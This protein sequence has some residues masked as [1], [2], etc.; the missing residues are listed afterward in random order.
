MSWFFVLRGLT[1]EGLLICG[2][3]LVQKLSPAL[4]EIFQ[5]Y[6][7]GFLGMV[8]TISAKILF[9]YNLSFRLLDHEA[10]EHSTKMTIMKFLVA[11]A[12]RVGDKT[13]V[14]TRS[15]PCLR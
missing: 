14:F 4:E 1:L 9:S 8:H 11:E 3:R 15:I 6:S 13:L 10:T 12:K 5:K 7:G 2:C